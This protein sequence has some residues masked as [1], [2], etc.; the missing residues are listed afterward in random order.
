MPVTTGLFDLRQTI[1]RQKES[2]LPHVEME[3][4]MAGAARNFRAP[5]NM[6]QS[7][8]VR[9]AGSCGGMREFFFADAV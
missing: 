1:P 5:M 3:F 9:D 7:A 4:A 2:F 8:Q 6:M